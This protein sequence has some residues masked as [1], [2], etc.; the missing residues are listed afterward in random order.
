MALRIFSQ[1]TS[2][3]ALTDLL[4]FT[5]PYE[6]FVSSR[7]FVCNRG[8]ATTF[9]IAVVP[10]DIDAVLPGAIN[11]IYFGEA[12]AA[13]TT[14]AVP[15]GITLARAD[16]IWVAGGAATLTFTLFGEGVGEPG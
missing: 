9:G 10:A 8:A 12:I 16:Q 1:I 11:Q 14:F 3:P 6:S 15:P 4:F 7:L 13:N 2:D 5:C